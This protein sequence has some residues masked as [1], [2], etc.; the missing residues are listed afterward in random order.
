MPHIEIARYDEVVF[1]MVQPELGGYLAELVHEVLFDTGRLNLE[2]DDGVL[3]D[4]A[5]GRSRLRFYWDK[6]IDDCVVRQ[7]NTHSRY[8]YEYLGNTERLAITPLT[9]RCYITLTTAL[10]LYRGGSPKGP[11]GTGKTETVK[12]LGKALG[13][14]VIV[15]NCSESLDYKSIGK[16]FSGLAQTGAWGCFDEFNRIDVE[17]LSVVAQQILSILSSLSQN[18]SQFIFEGSTIVL[19]PTCGIFITMNPGYAGRTELPDNLKSMFRPICM[20]KPDSAMIAEINLFG[21]GFRNT[22]ILA[23]KIFALYSLA[24]QQLSQQYHYDFGLRGI[25]TLT[26]YAGQKRRLHSH[27][28]DEEVLL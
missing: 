14:N 20:M 1:G 12:D 23:K 18:L 11:A 7:T 5:A 2:F 4:R 27:L 16:L 19:K 21:E 28:L 10:H 22:R 3:D 24:Q 17:V 6:D 8:G 9:D 26:R 13:F 15:Q 25:V